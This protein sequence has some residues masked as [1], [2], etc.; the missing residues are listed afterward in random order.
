MDGGAGSTDGGVGN[1]LL[2]QDERDF[3]FNRDSFLAGL[4]EEGF[5]AE[6]VFLSLDSDYGSYEN[7]CVVLTGMAP[8]FFDKNDTV[9]VILFSWLDPALTPANVKL[10]LDDSPWALAFRAFPA[11]RGASSAGRSLPSDIIIQEG[12]IGDPE[13]LR[14]IKRA[15]KE[16]ML[17]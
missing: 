11:M 13:V 17:Q 10:V 8:H 7:A 2:F 5:M 12:R 3:P 9:P 14:N 1:I 4:R 16:G 6:P 15:A